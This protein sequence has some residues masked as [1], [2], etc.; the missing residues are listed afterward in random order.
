MDV[1][2]PLAKRGVTDVS[3][4]VAAVGSRSLPKAQEFIE[5]YC[6]NGG[7]AQQDGSVDFK[8]DAVGSYQEVVDH[9]VSPH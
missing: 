6:P 2:R 1:C 8:T 3:H 4:A 5:K 7:V 9:P